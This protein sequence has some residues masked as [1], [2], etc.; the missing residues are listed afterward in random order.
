MVMG[1]LQ[2]KYPLRDLL[3][4][5]A[6]A[7]SSYFY[8]RAALAAEDKYAKLRERIRTAFNM[9]ECRYG[10]RRI[11]AV[12][13]RGGETISKKIKRRI[14]REEKLIVVGRTSRRYS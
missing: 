9:A 13:T 6:I 12:I 3:Q 2:N 5:L 4:Q 14:M 10:Y 8:Q 11:H 1:T 7:K